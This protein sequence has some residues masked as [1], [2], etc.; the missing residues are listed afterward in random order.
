MRKLILLIAV[1]FTSLSYT[2]E[3][4]LVGNKFTTQIMDGSNELKTISFTI[5]QETIE[6][7]KQSESYLKTAADTEFLKRNFEKRGISDPLV[8]YLFSKTNGAAFGTKNALQNPTSF[9]VIND[10]EGMI[11]YS[12]AG[13]TIS[14]L[15]QGKNNKGDIIK[16]TSIT[17]EKN[18]IISE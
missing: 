14:F 15:M 6:K 1:C 13:L 5:S 2:Q 10:K 3:I 12:S 18:T 7:I 17:N 4:K 11:Y 9:L 8:V 16:A